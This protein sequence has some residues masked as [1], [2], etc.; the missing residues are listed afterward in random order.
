MCS[1]YFE[2]FCLYSLK[3]PLVLAFNCY[4]SFVYIKQARC[5]SINHS[6]FKGPYWHLKTCGKFSQEKCIWSNCKCLLLSEF[7]LVMSTMKHWKIILVFFQ[8]FVAVHFL[9]CGCVVLKTFFHL[10]GRGLD[11]KENLEAFPLSLPLPVPMS[12]LVVL[13]PRW[14]ASCKEA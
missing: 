7:L 5:I 1:R 3:K 6:L 11:S 9:Y 8:P 10:P 4:F 2:W 13:R 12:F 14:V